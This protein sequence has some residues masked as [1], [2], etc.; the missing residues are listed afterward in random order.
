MKRAMQ[1]WLLSTASTAAFF[2]VLAGAVVPADAATIQRCVGSHGEPLFAEHC[3]NPVGPARLR[4]TSVSVAA[5]PANRASDYCARTPTSLAN[6]V[7]V[8]VQ[9]RNGVRL[10][11]FALW[12]G[13]SARIA[14]S[15]ARD[16]MRLLRAAS[17]NV[18]LMQPLQT[19]AGFADPSMP[20]LVMLRVSERAGVTETEQ[21]T[22]RIVRSHG[23]YWLDPQ[24]ERRHA[25]PPAQPAIVAE[26]AWGDTYTA[27]PTPQ[28]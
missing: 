25:A 15:E 4:P 7:G 14:R 22:F 28:P 20:T 16:L 2:A 17:V 24:P 13:M 10:S 18:V 3:A 21:W 1:H 6:G 9:A 19:D 11:G 12:R 8:A 26:S 5:A 23:C 27:L